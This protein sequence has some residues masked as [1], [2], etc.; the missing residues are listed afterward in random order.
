M[1]KNEAVGIRDWIEFFLAV[2][3]GYGTCLPS[4][5]FTTS[6]TI[7]WAAWP[8]GRRRGPSVI[9]STDKPESGLQYGFD[10]HDTMS[11]LYPIG[12]HGQIGRY[13][14]VMTDIIASGWT[15]VAVTKNTTKSDQPV[16]L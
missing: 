13:R 10:G 4:S 5:F 6:T 11:D 16:T 2:R 3:L 15:M 12:Q 14:E 8:C 9:F 1:D 7:S